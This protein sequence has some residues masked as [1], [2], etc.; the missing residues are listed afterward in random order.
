MTI[1][2]QPVDLLVSWRGVLSIIPLACPDLIRQNLRKRKNTVRTKHQCKPPRNIQHNNAPPDV[3]LCQSMKYEYDAETSSQKTQDC[4]LQARCREE[5][6]SSSRKPK[7]H[8][9][10]S[11][12]EM[13]PCCTARARRPQPP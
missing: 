9:L 5:R 13:Q 3:S 4:P 10:P 6:A 8:P 1:T 2:N 11:R 12:R 7:N